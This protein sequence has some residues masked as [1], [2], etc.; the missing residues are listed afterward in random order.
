MDNLERAKTL[1]TTLS[2]SNHLWGSLEIHRDDVQHA[3]HG[4]LS[5]LMNAAGDDDIVFAHAIVSDV[6]ADVYNV[7]AFTSDLVIDV[8][9]SGPAFGDVST[10]IRPRAD[11]ALVELL[12]GEASS[13][14]SFHASSL[15][16]PVSVTLTYRNGY[17]VGMTDRAGHVQTFLKDLRSDLVR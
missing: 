6:K 13:I 2:R 9:R 8:Y 10:S 12:G 14:G 15:S 17:V 16:S 5:A 7:V 1:N 11:L 4:T 3:L